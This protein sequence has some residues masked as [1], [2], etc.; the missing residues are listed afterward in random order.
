[1]ADTKTMTVD[2]ALLKA[3]ASKREAALADARVAEAKASQA[4]AQ[5]ESDEQAAHEAAIAARH[6]LRQAKALVVSALMAVVNPAAD[7]GNEEGGGD[8]T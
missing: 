6:G 3:Q 8:G 5:A 1:M 2:E 4:L 7:A